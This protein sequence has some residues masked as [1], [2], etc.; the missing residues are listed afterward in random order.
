MA[1]KSIDQRQTEAEICMAEIKKDVTFIKEEITDLKTAM[2]EFINN[3]PHK[4]AEK[5]IEEKVKD[6]DKKINE[7]TLK[8]AYIAGAAIVVWTFVSLFI[9]P[10]IKANLNIG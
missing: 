6:H 4:F 2:K 8:I 7:I 10:A 1:K 5:S 9:I 3:A